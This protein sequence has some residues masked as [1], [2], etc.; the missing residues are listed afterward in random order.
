MERLCSPEVSERSYKFIAV[1]D[2]R[3]RQE[4]FPSLLQK[5][6]HPCAHQ[7]PSEQVPFHQAKKTTGSAKR[8]STA[9]AEPGVCEQLPW[10]CPHLAFGRWRVYQRWVVGNNNKSKH[11]NSRSLF[12]QY[13]SWFILIYQA[14]P[15]HS[16]PQQRTSHSLDFQLILTPHLSWSIM[17]A[18][19]FPVCVKIGKKTLAQELLL[20]KYFRFSG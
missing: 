14:F 4:K 13:L 3:L 10:P 8:Y 1:K 15:R 16:D 2:R 5:T 9:K 20:Y 19:S 11:T 18:F 7:T 6:K 17:T 12:L